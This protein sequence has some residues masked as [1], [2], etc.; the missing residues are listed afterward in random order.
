MIT[1]INVK[2]VKVISILKLKSCGN[3]WV[4]SWCTRIYERSLIS[5]RCHYLAAAAASA[6]Q[7]Q[8]QSSHFA[9]VQDSY[10]T[11]LKHRPSATNQHHV[12]QKLEPGLQSLRGQSPGQLSQVWGG[13]R[14]LKVR[15]VEKRL[16]CSQSTWIRLCR[17]WGQPRRRRRGPCSGWN[18]RLRPISSASLLHHWSCFYLPFLF[19]FIPSAELAAPACE[20][21][22]RMDEAV[23]AAVDAMTEIAAMV[24]VGG[25]L[26]GFCCIWT[27]LL[28]LIS[29][30]FWQ[31]LPATKLL[32]K[33][34]QVCRAICWLI[35]SY[36]TN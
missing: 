18:V 23:A 5:A 15:P 6:A 8:F 11:F 3:F 36:S 30:I 24:V 17:V 10:S 27:P 19:T 7:A 29:P 1:K 31:W 2:S 14:L 35:L 16:G 9:I 13:G 32:S 33:P 34:L 22:C 26:L 21:K 4:C 12:V 25:K 28:N 20:W